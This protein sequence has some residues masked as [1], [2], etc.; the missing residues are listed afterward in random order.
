MAWWAL[1]AQ[2]T[3]MEALRPAFRR[4]VTPLIKSVLAPVE[5]LIPDALKSFLDIDKVATASTCV[6]M[7]ALTPARSLS[8]SLSLL[9]NST[10]WWCL[11][12]V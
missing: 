12:C 10:D 5:N 6:C 11:L 8:L 2:E 4:N 1:Q 7:W 9:A 3:F